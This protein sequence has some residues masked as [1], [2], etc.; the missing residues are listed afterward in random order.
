MKEDFFSKFKNYN[1]ELE[2]ILE[3]KEFSQDA[4]SLLLSMFYKLEASYEDY[5]IVKRHCKTKQEYLEKILDNIKITN[6]IL[7]VRPGEYYFEML[8]ENGLCQ[9]DLVYKKIIVLANEFALLK[10]LLELNNFQI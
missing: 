10:A 4:K 6:S 8:K 9:V 5:S 7:L 2:K 3:H 1:K